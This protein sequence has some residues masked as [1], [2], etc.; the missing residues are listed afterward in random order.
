[1]TIKIDSSKLVRASYVEGYTWS[2]FGNPK[3]KIIC[4]KCNAQFHTR[5]YVPLYENGSH[6]TDISCC[7][8]CGIWNKLG[9]IAE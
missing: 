3:L 2:V 7:Q 4:G 1:M 6:N 8:H 5:D 9:L